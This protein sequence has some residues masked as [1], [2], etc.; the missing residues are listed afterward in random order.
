MKKWYQSKKLWFTVVAGVS[1][2]ACNI[3]KL[4]NPDF[5]A[6]AVVEQIKYFYMLLVGGHVAES[7][8]H[9]VKK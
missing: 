8:A 4:Y 5:D 2:L 6:D 1:A 9:T 7:V 3:Y